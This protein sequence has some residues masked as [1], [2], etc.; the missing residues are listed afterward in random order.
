MSSSARSLSSQYAKT[1]DNTEVCV[2]FRSRTLPRSSG[3]NDE[4]VARTGAPSAPVSES[5]STGCEVGVNV[6]ASEAAR[7][8]MRASAA[9]PGAARPVRSPF[10]SATN[11][12]TPA[13]ESWPAMSCR[14][15]VLPVPVAPATSPW[16]FVVES[17]SVTRTSDRTSPPSIGLPSTIA[18]SSVA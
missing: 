13:A 9:S 15:F 18:G 14:V 1:I 16:R 3:P 12:G 4:I 11:T 17:G 10:T 7:S 2:S 5:S 6:H 8:W